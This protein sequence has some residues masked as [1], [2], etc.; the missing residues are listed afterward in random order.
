MLNTQYDNGSIN[1]KFLRK[2]STGWTKVYIQTKTT[3]DGYKARVIVDNLVYGE[4]LTSKVLRS[5]IAVPM[6]KEYVATL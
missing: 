3:T 1:E 6:A 2:D 5:N 4:G